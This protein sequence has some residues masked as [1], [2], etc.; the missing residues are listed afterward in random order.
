MNRQP[1]SSR[2]ATPPEAADASGAPGGPA[3]QAPPEPR[4]RRWWPLAALLV[5]VVLLGAGAR[6][7][8]AWLG[9]STDPIDRGGPALLRSI[10]DLSRFQAASG[11][12]Q[13]IVD[14]EKDA[15]FLPDA[16]KGTRTLFVGTGSVDAYVDF[17][18]LAED[19]VTVS[20]DGETVTVRVPRAQL[21]RTVIDNARSY[22]VAQRR[23]LI[24][25]LEEFL[26]SSPQDQRELYLAAEKKIAE[27]AAA[28][29]LRRRAER[30]T[31]AML[32]GMLKALGF[33][34]VVVEFAD[35]P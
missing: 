13:V 16:V 33:T 10:H 6:L 19:A 8:W 32:E 18:R 30:N 12:F 7:T 3:A 9:P 25:R 4:R 23:G 5:L 28:S 22:V 29:D 15:P 35:A 20:P 26:S 31:R 17:G 1:S 2:A 34:T 21:G 11:D 24:D 27:A 14:L